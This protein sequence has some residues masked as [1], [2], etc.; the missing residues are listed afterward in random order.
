MN[1]FETADSIERTD[2][3]DSEVAVGCGM[4]PRRACL[5]PIFPQPGHKSVIEVML[6]DWNTSRN[7]SKNVLQTGSVED[8]GGPVSDDCS[9]SGMDSATESRS[10]SDSG[11]A[12]TEV[13]KR[14][15]W[16][17]KF[18]DW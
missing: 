7:S 13:D 5:T 17:I 4:V 6:E 8:R 3:L 2:D 16:E 12:I 18:P 11:S 15:N 14:K 10:E 1:A 9:S